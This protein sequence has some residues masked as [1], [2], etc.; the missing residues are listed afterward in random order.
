MNILFLTMSQF[1]SIYIHNIYADLMLTFID[2][3]YRPYI[4]SP[5]E[6]CF[7]QETELFEFSDYVNLKVN[8]GNMSNVSLF[9]K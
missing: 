1:D 7:A 6:K 5:Y 9:E 2:N 8:V 3:G 4:V